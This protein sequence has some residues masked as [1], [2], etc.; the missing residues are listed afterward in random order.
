MTEC[1]RY[2]SFS[3]AEGEGRRRPDEGEFCNSRSTTNPTTFT[4][5]QPL[6]FKG[7]G[8]F[9]SFDDHG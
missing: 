6:S 8:V 2:D 5:T 9:D 4:L 1:D 3:P 7:E